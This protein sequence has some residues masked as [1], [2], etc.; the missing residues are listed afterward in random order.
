MKHA[1]WFVLALVCGPAAAY[2]DDGGAEPELPRSL[3]EIYAP[4]VQDSPEREGPGF[5]LGGMAGYVRAR[6]ADR[7]T[8][9]AGVVARLQ[10]IP[11]L[12]AE[13]N[14][15][16]H[17]DEFADGDVTVTTYPVQVTGL[18]YPLPK[19]PLRPYGL[20]G[21]GWYYT[22]VDFDDSIGG[23]DDT[24]SQFAVHVGVGGEIDLGKRFKIF[25]DF[26]WI[27]LDEPGVDNS[28]IED[29]EFD[30]YMVTIGGLF[31]F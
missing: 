28:N 15:S 14:I 5:S 25:A 1:A 29:E 18:F 12:A 11:W 22:R 21:A 4:R 20:V 7:G 6:D 23:G 16:F 13:A 24:D 31:R 17:Q 27:F 8:W 19:L 10:I 26:R 30:T 3:G 2:A 9:H